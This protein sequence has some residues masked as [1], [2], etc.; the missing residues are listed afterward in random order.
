MMSRA[1]EDEYREFVTVK[2]G[3]L[4]KVAYFGTDSRR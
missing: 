1:D 2:A 4:F 3:Q